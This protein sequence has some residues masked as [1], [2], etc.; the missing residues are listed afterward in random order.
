VIV[1]ETCSRIGDALDALGEMHDSTSAASA[2]ATNVRFGNTPR[3][4]SSA[5]AAA[6]I[7]RVRIS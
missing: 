6:P 2:S 3:V 7:E 1:H 5:A 4:Y